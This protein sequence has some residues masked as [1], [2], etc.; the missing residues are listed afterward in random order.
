MRPLVVKLSMVVVLTVNTSRQR[1]SKRIMRAP[2]MRREPTGRR[3]FEL[4]TISQAQQRA[5][6][7][8]SYSDSKT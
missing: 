6:Q 2:R 8:A 5:A 3:G 7:R 4:F 1:G